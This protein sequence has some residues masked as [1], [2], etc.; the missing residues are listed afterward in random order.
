MRAGSA[1][2]IWR[3]GTR[4]AVA[5]RFEIVT[6]GPGRCLQH[7]KHFGSCLTKTFARTYVC[8]AS[9]FCSLPKKRLMKH[10]GLVAT[11]SVPYK[12]CL[13]VYLWERVHWPEQ[14]VRKARTSNQ[15]SVECLRVGVALV[16]PGV[17]AHGVIDAQLLGCGA[18]GATVV[19]PGGSVVAVAL[20]K[21]RQGGMSPI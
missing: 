3:L 20:E 18:G 9:I 7:C 16:E 10:E 21:D 17:V 15:S 4:R 6:V 2:F 1:P 8:L 13:L 11:S 12:A 14:P 19:G 5:R